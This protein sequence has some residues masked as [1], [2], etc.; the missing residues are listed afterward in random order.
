[1]QHFSGGSTFSLALIKHDIFRTWLVH[2]H[3]EKPSP[4]HRV[5]GRDLV[6]HLAD[7]GDQV[8]R[9]VTLCSALVEEKGIVE[10]IYR[11]AGITSNVQVPLHFLGSVLISLLKGF[12]EGFR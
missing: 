1:M 8:P 5:F 7:S 10:G 4:T 6:D 2:R 12:A 11:L 9:V 3:G